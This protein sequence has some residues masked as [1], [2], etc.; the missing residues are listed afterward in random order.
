M[1][2]GPAGAPG[3]SDKSRE[4]ELAHRHRYRSGASASEQLEIRPP[5]RQPPPPKQWAP[6]RLL[7]WI[8]RKWNGD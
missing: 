5:G 8:S 1:F 6:L 4:K 2:V 7:T 3:P